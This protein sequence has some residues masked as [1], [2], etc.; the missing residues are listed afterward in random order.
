M[1]QEPTASRPVRIAVIGAGNRANKYL[2]YA[3]RCPDRLQPVA[4][5]E[6]NDLRRRAFARDFGLPESRS[7]VHYDDFFADRVEADMVLI[8]TPE[9]AHFD[10]AVKAIDAGYHILL[11]K[12]IAQHL[13]QCREIARRARERGV[14][15]GVCHVLRYHPYF[16]KIRELIASGEFG[17]IVSVEHTAAVGLDRAT[18]SY[19]RGI[20][21]RVRESNPILLAKCC[22][23]IDFLLWITGSH[24]RRLTSFGSLRWFR[25]ENAPAGSGERCLACAI[26]PDCPFSA[27]DLYYVRRDWVANFDVPPGKTL[28][29][30]IL[31]ELRTGLYGRCV[32]HCDNDVVDHQLVAMEMDD[33]VTVS[34]SMEMFTNDDFRKTHIRLTEGEIDG[35]E[36]TLRVRRFRGGYEHT[37]DFSDIAGQP[38]HAGADLQLIEDFIGALR[39]PE[40]P[41]LTTIDDSIESHR[42]CYEAERSRHTGA[43]IHMERD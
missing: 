16:V 8:S 39:N 41:F 31:D 24:C 2:E 12:P 5:V 27:R 20:F 29:E 11:E 43:T 15:V 38:F 32:Y 30:T 9:N 19:V 33:E 42:I 25:A 34:L 17:R 40:R 26:E 28:D 23:D 10:P 13:D 36:R 1:K 4:V 37:Y 3:R 6:V 35:D 18:H 21:R 22:H 7:Y 14:L